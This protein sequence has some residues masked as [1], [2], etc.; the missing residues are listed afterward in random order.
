MPLRRNQTHAISTSKDNDFESGIHYHATGTGKSW[1]AMNIMNEFHKKYPKANILWLCERKDILNQQFSREALIDRGFKEILK[2]YNILD[3]A[4]KKCANWYDSLNSSTF[5]GLPFLCIINRCFLTTKTKYRNIKRD[6]GLVIHDECHSIENNTTQEFYKWLSEHSPKAKIIGFSATPE[7]IKPLNNL[8]TSYS[9]YDAFCDKVI[10]PPKVV[11]VKTENTMTEAD[12]LAVVEREISQLPYKKLV[13]WCGTVDDCIRIKESWD[14]KFPDFIKAVDYNNCNDDSF[15]RFYRAEKNA[16]LFCAVKHREGSDIPN[17][18]GCVFMDKVEKRSERVFIQSMGRVLR[19]DKAGRKKYGLVVDVRAKSSIEVCNR[20]QYYLKL[21]DIFPWHYALEVMRHGGKTYYINSLTMKEAGIIEGKSYDMERYEKSD[22]TKQFVRNIPEGEEYTTRLDKEIT[23]MLEKN[24]FGNVMRAMEILALTKD[25][26]HVTRGSC[27]S[28]LVCYLL[29]ISHVDPVKHNISF[30][31]FI[32]QYRTTLPDIDFDFPHYLRDEVFLKLFQKWGSKVAR[33]SNHNYYHEKSALRESL[34]RN[35]V[36]EF[37]SKY[38]LQKKID[39][40]DK[41]FQEQIY[42]T[43]KELDG[44]FRGYSLHCGG[45]IYFPDGVPEEYILDE[46]ERKIIPQVHLNK[47]DVS[48]QKTFKIDILSSRALSQLYYCRHFKDIDFNSHVG[49]EATI[50]LLCSGN[51]VGITLAETPLMKK[52]LILVRPKTIMD[53]AICLAIIRPAAKD[54]K[55]EFEMGKVKK[56]T[57]IFDDDIIQLLAKLFKCDEE[58]ADKFR[59]G[60]CKDDKETHRLIEKKLSVRP[61]STQTRIKNILSNLRKYGFCKSHALSYAQLVWQ[62]AYEKAHHPETF[63]KSTLKNTKTC[64]RNWVHIYE[65]RCAGV[66]HSVKDNE[67]SL[68]AK[69][70]QHDYSAAKPLEQLR[71]A[72]YWYGS[73]FYKGCYYTKRDDLYLFHGVVASSRLVKRG[74]RSLLILCVGISEKKFIE[75]LVNGRT[76]Y[77]T[78]KVL[79]QGRGALKRDCEHFPAIECKAKEMMFI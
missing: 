6:I 68:Y 44:T 23:L 3:Y 16:L 37:I 46:S 66:G 45:I 8:I 11:W 33:I 28:S 52:A 10:L 9:I 72:G 63:W 79:V 5:W 62:L 55:K 78:K 26:P 35:G 41:D 77:N 40:F 69:Q 36:N 29:G 43:Q 34:R 54:A 7:Y 76:N 20:V 65:A 31:R 39:S 24:L 32:N 56:H 58:I 47:Y 19:L 38:E 21:K 4:N 12:I 2:G 57:M 50:A 60:Y 75:V 74:K 13:I 42:D 73:A 71:N 49:D 67:G 51:N 14:S 61:K 70:R 53:L 30:A 59:R 64:Y 48:E 18:D 1:I 25:I 22:I 17:L 27:G 15:D